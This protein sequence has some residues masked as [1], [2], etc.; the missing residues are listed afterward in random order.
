MFLA[1]LTRSGDRPVGVEVQTFQ[2]QILVAVHQNV[3]CPIFRHPTDM[4]FSTTDRSPGQWQVVSNAPLRA[5][6]TLSL[7]NDVFFFS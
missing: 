1:G 2:V 7:R 3:V 4:G 5:A 6:Q